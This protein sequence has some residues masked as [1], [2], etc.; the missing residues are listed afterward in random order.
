MGA[1]LATAALVMTRG[2]QGSTPP[3]SSPGI[4]EPVLFKA[5]RL[6]RCGLQAMHRPTGSQAGRVTHTIYRS[7]LRDGERL[8]ALS[9]RIV[10]IE[11]RSDLDRQR[12]AELGAIQRAVPAGTILAPATSDATYAVRASAGGLQLR[13]AR[14]S[15]T[16]LHAIQ[17]FRGRFVGGGRR[18][19]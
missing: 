18:R 16:A 14:A 2:D 5:M 17:L 10:V 3:H 12:V 13:C 15:D 9:R 7:P 4:R 1:V 11:Y 19:G 6:A 8:A